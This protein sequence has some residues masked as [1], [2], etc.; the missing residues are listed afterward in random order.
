MYFYTRISWEEESI[1][2]T[3][4]DDH[5]SPARKAVLFRKAD[6]GGSSDNFFVEGDTISRHTEITIIP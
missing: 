1:K 2:L 3:C 5:Q 6:P 4:T